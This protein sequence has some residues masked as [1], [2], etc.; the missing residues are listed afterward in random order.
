MKQRKIA[1]SLAVVA[2]VAVPFVFHTYKE[3]PTGKV[4]V[5]LTTENRKLYTARLMETNNCQTLEDYGRADVRNL[6]ESC[7]LQQK[8]LEAGGYYVSGRS[9][10]V[11]L[12]LNAAVAAVAFVVIF[13]LTYLLPALARR[14]WRWLNT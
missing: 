8:A 4:W 1:I 9:M 7:R 12:T 13:G 5:S 2:A 6:L 10:P 11:Y 3:G 14:Y